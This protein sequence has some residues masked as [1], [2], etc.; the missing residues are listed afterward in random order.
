[1][2]ISINPA[3]LTISGS[4]A[5]CNK[6]TF[7]PC[8]LRMRGPRS[9]RWRGPGANGDC[10]AGEQIARLARAG[11]DDKESSQRRGPGDM[12][13]AAVNF[14]G[15]DLASLVQL[16]SLIVLPFAHE[17]LAIVLGAYIVVNDLMPVGLVA[18][19][20]YGGIVVS[21][22]ALYGIGAGA[23]RLPWLRRHAVDD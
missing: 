19:S 14:T 23:R 6:S 4:I 17:D 13:N 2:V 18:A 8:A 15:Y 9:P 12:V 10:A 1:M 5:S 7:L 20:I 22:F 16:F 21:D 3:A 11:P